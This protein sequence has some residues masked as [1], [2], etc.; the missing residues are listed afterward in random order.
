MYKVDLN[1]DLGESFG[2][3]TIGLDNEVVQYVSSVNVACGYHAGDPLVMD[4]TVAAAKAAGVAV[5]AHPGYPDL[6]GFGRR[7]MALTAEEVKNTVIYQIGALESFCRA[8]GIKLQH[9]K[10]HGALYNN[11]EKDL[12]I[13]TAIAEA[14]KAV[15][16]TLYMLCLANSQMGVAA[17]NAGLPYVE[18]AFADRAY[19][20]E[21]SLVSRKI[22][23]SVIHDLDQV[24]SRVVQMVRDKTVVSIHGNLVPIQ[25][26]TI[27]VHGDTPG[28][29]SMVK[30]IRAALE[31]E[32]ISLRAFGC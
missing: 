8:A 9:V 4:K 30:A 12:T 28:A 27:C 32:K 3:Y 20:D 23:G 29:V 16:P 24:V 22:A 19:T 14:I 10:V 13:A 11:A 1:S 15:D 17:R 7:S 2:A 21:G 6:V 18:E 25:A 31:K 5:G 26:Q